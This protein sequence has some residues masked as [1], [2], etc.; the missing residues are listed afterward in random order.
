MVA[1]AGRDAVL[2]GAPV[3][4]ISRFVTINDD[5]VARPAQQRIGTFAADQP[6]VTGIACQQVITGGT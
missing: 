4:K 6:V 2:A 1:G 3:Q 5:V